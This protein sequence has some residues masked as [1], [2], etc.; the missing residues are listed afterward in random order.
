LG[1]FILRFA[2]NASSGNP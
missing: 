2:V 1:G